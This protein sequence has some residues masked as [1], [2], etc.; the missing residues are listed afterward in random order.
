[1]R[2][3]KMKLSTIFGMLLLTICMGLGIISYQ[4]AEKALTDNTKDS[5]KEL[6]VEAS[7]TVTSE[8]SN[9]LNTL[10]V[11]SNTSL[12]ESV[13]NMEQKQEDILT[14]LL[15]I[16]EKYGYVHVA[17]GIGSS[18]EILYED[19]TKENLSGKE[20]FD[21]VMKGEEVVT[22]P[23]I[24][25]SNELMI[26]FGVPILKGDEIIGGLFGYRSAYELGEITSGLTFGES[27]NVYIV[28]AVGNT[29]SHSN[30]EKLDEILKT[31]S[32]GKAK[33]EDN[34][35]GISSASV[36]ESEESSNL[37]GFEDFEEVHKQ[38]LS[39]ESGFGE[40]TEAGVKKYMGYAPIKDTGWILAMEMD[41][42]EVLSG[43]NALRINIVLVS[44]VFIIL[45]FI[46]VSV[47]AGKISK[48]ISYLTQICHTMSL[49]DFNQTVNKKYLKRNDE[50][51]KLSAAFQS[52]ADSF[53]GLLNDNAAVAKDIF[54]SSQNLD[55]MIQESTLMIEE[56]AKTVEQIAMGSNQQTEN[57]GYGVDKI[58]EMEELIKKEEND[59][60]TLRD[61]ADSVE[62]LKNEGKHI[63][64]ELVVKT[65]SNT[66]I[67]K[68][69]YDIILDTHES[70]TKIQAIS[71][72]ISNIAGQTNLLALN[73]AIEAARAGED[74]KGF[75]VV[76]QEIRKLSEET[77]RFS[78]DINIII[79]E[80]RM[81]VT[82]AVDKMEDVLRISSE[83]AEYVGLTQDKFSGISSAVEETK[84]SIQ[85][86]SLSVEETDGKKEEIVEIIKELHNLS[87]ENT[88]GTEEVSHSMQEQSMYMNEILNVSRSL[89][90]MAA[91]MEEA[92]SKFIF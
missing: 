25:S 65:K 3:I 67:S 4:T 9:Y 72:M 61:S 32:N 34:V 14:T 71:E 18:N 91:K 16:K 2:T 82:G 8:V 6:T 73:A 50:I 31:I 38:M 44:V 59:M 47:A 87:S 27:G 77:N 89:Y 56:E 1:M 17:L 62:K 21:K 12:F 7:N 58:A 45:G 40:Y 60:S 86:L 53:K 19:G 26:I 66:D 57:I 55:H 10:W 20:Y 84:R 78:S 29:I 42:G 75:S 28:N 48:P 68:E 5:M 35:D 33:D 54:S 52:I 24:S 88:A 83:Q 46:I 85:L 64:N 90:D 13:S 43:L 49:G 36:N 30:K 74:G 39:G 51:G 37:L 22:D 69:I 23:L 15:Q 92:A 63:L 81:K 80:L 79:D 70:T 41:K 76:A 11:L